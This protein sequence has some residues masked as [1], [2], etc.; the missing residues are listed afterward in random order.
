MPT[1][2]SMWPGERGAEHGGHADRVLVHVRLHVL[3][4]DRV[5]VL[6]E[7]DDPRLHVEVAAELLPDHVHVA[8]EDEVGP[9]HGLARRLAALAPV[10]LQRQRAEHDRLGGA[11][12]ARPGRLPRRVEQ[13]GQHPDAALLDLRGARVLGVVDE[14]AVEVLGDDPLRLGLHPGGHERG[15]VV[16]GSPSRASSSP[17]RRIASTAGIPPSGNSCLRHL[18]G[19]EPVAVAAGQVVCA[20]GCVGHAPIKSRSGR[21]T[22]HS[23]RVRSQARLRAPAPGCRLPAARPRRPGARRISFSVGFRTIQ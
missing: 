9:V 23:N 22:H 10:P 14:V 1:M 11:L 12:R 21:A 15:E 4:A 16:L 7:R 19:E 20:R 2:S 8:A 18:L 5:L 6:R 3:G 13:V 17:I